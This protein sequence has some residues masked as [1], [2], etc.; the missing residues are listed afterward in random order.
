MPFATEDV[1]WDHMCGRSDDGHWHGSVVIHVRSSALRALGL[2]PD[3]PWPD[4]R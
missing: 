1:Y 4:Q 3:A 2:H